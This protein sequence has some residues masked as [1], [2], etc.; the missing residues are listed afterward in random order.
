MDVVSEEDSSTLS[1]EVCAVSQNFYVVFC[2]LETFDLWSLPLKLSLGN[3]SVFPC[4]GAYIYM[5]YTLNEKVWQFLWDFSE[6]V[7]LWFEVIP[8]GC[9]EAKTSVG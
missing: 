7:H 1:C 3:I 9:L 2:F 4:F 6:A 5:F 8:H